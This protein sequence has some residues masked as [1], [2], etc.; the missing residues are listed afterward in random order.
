M[1]QKTYPEYM[2]HRPRVL[3]YSPAKPNPEPVESPTERVKSW[4]STAPSKPS[5]LQSPSIRNSEVVEELKKDYNKSYRPRSHS[6][7]TSV[8]TSAYSS[9]LE[10]K[11]DE[12]KTPLDDIGKKA[13]LEKQEKDRIEAIQKQ[14]IYKG[15]SNPKDW[16]RLKFIQNYDEDPKL[17]KVAVKIKNDIKQFKRRDW[18]AEDSDENDE[19]DVQG[20]T[21]KAAWAV[22]EECSS[23]DNRFETAELIEYRNHDWCVA[24]KISRDKIG[25]TGDYQLLVYSSQCGIQRLLLTT[26][27]IDALGESLLIKY[28]FNKSGSTEVLP[29]YSALPSTGLLSLKYRNNKGIELR[30]YGI[31]NFVDLEKGHDQLQHRTVI[32]TDA[33]G[34][35]YLTAADRSNIRRRLMMP[36]HKIFAPLRMCQLVVKGDFASDVLDGTFLKWKI[37]SF[38][39]LVEETPKDPNIGR[40]LWPARVIRLDD[41][42]KEA[43]KTP[44]QSSTYQ[45]FYQ[46]SGTWLKSISEKEIRVFAGTHLTGIINSAGP[47]Y[48]ERGIMMAFVVPYFHQNKFVYYEALVAGPPRVVMMITEG[49][50]LNYSP[51]TFSP[52]LQKM[53]RDYAKKK[54]QKQLVR[55]PPP[56]MRQ[57]EYRLKSRAGFEEF[58]FDF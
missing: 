6:G 17:Q 21:N 4:I 55:D 35:I 10:L 16:P 23:E 51:K 33:L 44:S 14:W 29:I 40:N 15:F 34:P 48:A 18:D 26:E 54:E 39:P 12:L 2:L 20:N 58:H 36:E 22:I 57:P 32:W 25:K 42:V 3:H 47:N 8:I 43:K 56:A 1:W 45:H 46:S 5:P 24:L 28:K 31:A 38:T 50:F 52:S 49:R 41:L 13:L 9:Q 7:Q 27:Q 53:V 11:L 30:V 19:R 37:T